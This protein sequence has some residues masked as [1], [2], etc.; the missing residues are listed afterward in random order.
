MILAGLTSMS[1]SMSLRS[2]PA[3]GG[4]KMTVWSGSI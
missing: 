3:R 2:Q 4:S 1:L